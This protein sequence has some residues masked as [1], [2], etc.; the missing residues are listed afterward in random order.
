MTN[1]ILDATTMNPHLKYLIPNSLYFTLEGHQ[2]AN[3][4]NGGENKHNIKNKYNIYLDDE[5]DK[6]DKMSKFN[7]LYFCLNVLSSEK[8]HQGPSYYLWENLY[9]L[10]YRKFIDKITGKIIIIDNHGS[11]YEPNIYLNKF[12]FKYDIILKRV[13]SNRNIKK[14]QKNT[15]SYPFVM[16]TSNDPM[17]KLF[18]SNIII[19]PIVNKINKIYFSGSLF[20]HYENFDDNNVFESADR[21]KII[22]KFTSKYPN[23]LNIKRVSYDIFHKTISNHKYA[24]DIRG[25]SRLNKR[26]YEILSTN[27][28]LLAERIDI[29]WPFEDGDSFSKECFF[30]QGNADDLYRIYN[31]LENNPQLYNKCLENQL[32]IVNKYFNN[33]WIWNYIEDIIN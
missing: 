33:E 8:T 16:C 2:F 20:K 19:T 27:T 29:I 10:L 7:N 4:W 1:L 30:E 25:C 23:I 6:I 32:Y 26:L 9:K 14:Y 15:F 12:N 21:V 5:I 28:L 18:N 3:M 13:Y 31:N 22:N 17:Y 24:L 11:D